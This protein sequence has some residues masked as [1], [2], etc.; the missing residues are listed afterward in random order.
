M[1][2]TASGATFPLSMRAT[3]RTRIHVRAY[4]HDMHFFSRA[5]RFQTA[6]GIMVLCCFVLSCVEAEWRAPE[7]TPVYTLFE[8]IEVC[9]HVLMC[10]FLLLWRRLCL[11][12]CLCLWLCLARRSILSVVG[13]SR[14]VLVLVPVCLIRCNG[15]DVY[16][17]CNLTR[18]SEPLPA[19]ACALHV[20]AVSLQAEGAGHF[21]VHVRTLY[22]SS[23]PS[24]Y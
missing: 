10:M 23:I 7:G 22:Q 17:N 1:R 14:C 18:F 3:E 20:H 5:N 16:R 6:S 11:C 19:T 8:I 4:A 15:V 21:H 9:V 12:L 2:L 24:L 13:L